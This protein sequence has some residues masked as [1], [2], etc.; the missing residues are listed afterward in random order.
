MRFAAGVVQRFDLGPAVDR[1]DDMV[2]AVLNVVAVQAD[3][4]AFASVFPCQSP[5]PTTSS[6]NYDLAQTSN[7]VVS[8][9]TDDGEICVVTNSSVEIVIDLVGVFVGP[10]GSLVNQ[11]SLT[12]AGGALVPLEQDFAVDGENATLRCDGDVELGLRLGLAPGVSAEVERRRRPR[13]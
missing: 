5:P 10:E 11:L 13:T 7:L 8:A 12:D 3:R 4:S 1:P 2:A 6:L 9:V